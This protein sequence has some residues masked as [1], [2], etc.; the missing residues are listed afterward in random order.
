MKTE[1]LFDVKPRTR[2]YLAYI[3]T[4]GDIVTFNRADSYRSTRAWSRRSYK[5]T[6]ASLI[7]LTRLFLNMFEPCQEVEDNQGNRFAWSTCNGVSLFELL[8]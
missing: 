8:P 2:W 6:T 7:R 4:E 3:R 1:S 5:P